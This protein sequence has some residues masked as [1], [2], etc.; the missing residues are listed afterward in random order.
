MFKCSYIIGF[1][2]KREKKNTLTTL[3]FLNVY[4]LKWAAP[5]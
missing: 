5:R 2:E 1:Y 3:D 4:I